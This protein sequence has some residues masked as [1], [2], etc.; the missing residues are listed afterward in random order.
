M[1][2]ILDDIPEAKRLDRIVALLG[3]L[4]RGEVLTLICQENP[5]DLAEKV[6]EL[7]GGVYDHQA[8]HVN[9][10]KSPPWLLHLKRKMRA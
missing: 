4:T 7:T 6:R 8:I 9:R 3:D 1:Q 2:A 5:A 10:R